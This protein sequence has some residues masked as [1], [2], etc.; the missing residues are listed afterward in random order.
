V[1]IHGLLDS[2]FYD[3]CNILFRGTALYANEDIRLYYTETII[4]RGVIFLLC[5]LLYM[6][7]CCAL[8]QVGQQE[9]REYLHSK[10]R[11]HGSV[12]S[13]STDRISAVQTEM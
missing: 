1:R 12:C 2:K 4:T 9:I 5:L 10:L 6:S 3:T 8:F 13:G 11:T 7:V